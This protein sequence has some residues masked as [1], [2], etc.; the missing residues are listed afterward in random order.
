MWISFASEKKY[1]IK[2]YV[3]AVNAVSGE[4]CVETAATTL[5]RR[6]RFAAKESI[7]DYVVTPDQRWLDGIATSAGQVRQFV[8]MPMGSGYSVEAQVTG[9]EVAGGLQFEITP[10][11]DKTVFV[12][13]LTGR[14]VAVAIDFDES[15]LT[16][17]EII[18]DM[19]NIPVSRQRLVYAGRTVDG[20]HIVARSRRKEKANRKQ[21]IKY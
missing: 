20:A 1:A 18:S 7:Q 4:P 3:G 12:R 13:T 14:T 16:L 19:E 2:I 8:A 10:H 15:I 9:Q 6:Q 11:A 17:K 21:I 5:R